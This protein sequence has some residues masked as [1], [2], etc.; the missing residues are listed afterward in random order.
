LNIAA[1]PFTAWS[2]PKRGP[3]R[4]PKS[5]EKK[6]CN[7]KEASAKKIGWLKNL[8]KKLQKMC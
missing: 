7:D 3:K 4:G 6:I 5:R 1:V 8:S 2:K